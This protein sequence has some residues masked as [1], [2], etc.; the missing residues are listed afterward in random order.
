MVERFKKI[1]RIVEYQN[2]AAVTQLAAELKVSDATIRKDLKALEKQ[3]HLRRTHGGAVVVDE[4]TSRE[5]KVRESMGRNINEKR[6]IARKA[7]EMIKDDEAIVLDASSTAGMICE[8]IKKAGNRR[9]TV[10]TNSAIVLM[11]LIDCEN[12]QVIMIGGQVRSSVASCVGAF[13]T[14][15]LRNMRVDKAFIGANGIDLQQDIITTPNLFER[16]VKRAMISAARETVIVADNT[17]FGRLY[18]G[19]IC[20]LSEVGCIITDDGISPD[21]IKR[22]E[23]GNVNIVVGDCE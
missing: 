3:G 21:T 11:E 4:G 2:S 5:A 20:R 15:M 13:A 6:K 8:H 14:D 16:E 10:V 17:K 19:V 22:A 12:I 7:Y 18:L 23:N 1:R 9:L